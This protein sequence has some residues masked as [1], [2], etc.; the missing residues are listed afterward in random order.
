MIGTVSNDVLGD[1]RPLLS[2][3]RRPED[4][5]CDPTTMFFLPP[6]IATEV[7]IEKVD[8]AKVDVA[9]SIDAFDTVA[10]VEFHEVAI[11]ESLP[12]ESP[13]VDLADSQAS[14][15]WKERDNILSI[16]TIDVKAKPKPNISQSPDIIVRPDPKLAVPDG[17]EQAT[18]LRRT[19]V[20]P[21]PWVTLS[22]D[23][24]VATSDPAQIFRRPI[25]QLITDHDAGYRSRE[26]EITAA[27][28]KVDRDVTPRKVASEVTVQSKTAS[29]IEFRPAQLKRDP[30]LSRTTPLM[31]MP[32]EFDLDRS[33]NISDAIPEPV[34]AGRLQIEEA[35]FEVLFFVKSAVESNSKK[36]LNIR[37]H[38][39]ELGSLNVTIEKNESGATNARFNVTTDQAQHELIASLGNLRE[40]LELAGVQVGEL[41]VHRDPISSRNNESFD[42]AP[43]HSAG[44]EREV[45]SSVTADP[46]ATNQDDEM[47]RLLNLRA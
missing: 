13:I 45:A 14:G 30:Q 27:G 20:T 34:E 40:A 1:V 3:R 46:A 24:A 6:V 9:T 19:N 10:P 22:P 8:V 43:N 44:A 17:V 47:D 38:P 23:K 21:L 35:Q 42:D 5:E 41:S 16:H 12:A 32:M 33:S 2:Q 29:V 26:M 18:D 28:A 4:G 39:E 25:R 15:A 11:L 7:R 31:Q 36:S 37:L